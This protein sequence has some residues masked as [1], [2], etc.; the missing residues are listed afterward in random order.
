MRA[1]V[2]TRF[3]RPDVLELADRPAPEPGPGAVRVAVRAAGVNFA[4]LAARLG[5]YRKAPR[6]PGVLGFEFSGVVDRP[7]PGANRFAA[8]DRV[9]GAC[10][11]GGYAEMA[12]ASEADLIPLPEGMSYEEGAAL[13]VNYA[14]AYAGLVR[15]GGLR[16]GER[17]LVQSAGGGVGV[18]AT[19]LA[20]LEGAEV[21]GTASAPKHDALR[22]IGVDHPIDYRSLDF[23]REVRRI[24]GSKQPIDIALDPVA[25]SSHRRSY[26]LLA[27]GGRLVCYGASAAFGGEGRSLLRAARMALGS[28]WFSS[29]R[30]GMRSRAVIGLDLGELWEG[31]GDLR[32]LTEPLAALLEQG[33]IRPLVA[34][35]FPLERGAD[36]HRF[37]HARRNVGKVVLTV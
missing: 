19:Q 31:K 18:A 12:V 32:E 2:M 30:L 27:P 25:G 36:A 22:R 34:E 5:L 24:A 3:G 10:W 23:R 28:P 37:L 8:G 11:F 1:L 20:K 7:G 17:V 4:D 29:F 16:R 21:F 13:P 35:S 26:S 9:V 15:Y 14:A 6:P 33:R